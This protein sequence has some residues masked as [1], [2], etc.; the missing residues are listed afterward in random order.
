MLEE[1]HP[2]TVMQV[3]VTLLVNWPN[4]DVQTVFKPKP[5][6]AVLESL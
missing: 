3:L 2:Y 4:L 1:L 6:L 5:V